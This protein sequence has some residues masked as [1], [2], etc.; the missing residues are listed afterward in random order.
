MAKIKTPTVTTNTPD[1]ETPAVIVDYGSL[2]VQISALQSG[3]LEAQ[4]KVDEGNIECALTAR[5]FREANPEA[6]REKIRLAVATSIAETRG[7][8]VDDIQ[9]APDK[10]LNSPS[11]TP[12]Q[13]EKYAL[14]KYAYELLSRLMS[15]AWPKDEDGEKRVAKLIE[16][17]ERGFVKLVAA[18][19]KKQKNPATTPTDEGKI[20]EENFG[21]RLGLFLTKALLDLGDK[22]TAADIAAMCD[23]ASGAWLKATET[24]DATK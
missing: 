17:G 2:T 10:S 22:T 14:R 7:L 16:S 5:E 18:A 12:L 15:V 4:G 13:K 9:K 8:K 19:A 3:V 24:P 1:V 21:T 20:T 23:V 11:A 6:E